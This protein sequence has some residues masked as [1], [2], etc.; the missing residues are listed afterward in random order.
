MLYAIAL[1]S[2]NDLDI[3]LMFASPWDKKISNSYA[4]KTV[5]KGTFVL[6]VFRQGTAKP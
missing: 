1:I 5:T 4:L 3:N 6:G 2:R